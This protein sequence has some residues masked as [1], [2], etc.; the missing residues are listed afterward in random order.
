MGSAVPEATEAVA[1]AGASTE[2]ASSALE[3][4]QGIVAALPENLRFAGLLILVGAVL[5]GVATVQF[6]DVSLF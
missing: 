1:A 2:A 3:Q 4:V 5:M 6:G